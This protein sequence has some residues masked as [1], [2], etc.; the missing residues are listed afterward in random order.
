[1]VRIAGFEHAAVRSYFCS[2]R[3]ASLSS[4]SSI[5]PL[6]IVPEQ[7]PSQEQALLLP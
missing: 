7:E 3:K 6:V 2:Y 1:M 4:R 5:S